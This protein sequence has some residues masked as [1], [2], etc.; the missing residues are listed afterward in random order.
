MTPP[1]PPTLSSAPTSTQAHTHSRR[2]TLRRTHGRRI[3]GEKV[4]IEL[5][6][7]VSSRPTLPPVSGKRSHRSSHCELV[8]SDKQQS[9]TWVCCGCAAVPMAPVSPL[10]TALA[11]AHTH[12]HTGNARSLLSRIDTPWHQRHLS[13]ECSRLVT[14]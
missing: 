7:P 10:R 9:C 4:G 2:R 3:D 13:C 14:W 5:S 8:L 1:P 11:V 12:L 6:A